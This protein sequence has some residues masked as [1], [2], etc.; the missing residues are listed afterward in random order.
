MRLP[1]LQHPLEKQVTSLQELHPT[2]DFLQTHLQEPDFF[3]F[4]SNAFL[5]RPILLKYWLLHPFST[6]KPHVKTAPRKD[7]FTFFTHLRT[8]KCARKGRWVISP[9]Y[10]ASHPWHFCASWDDSCSKIWPPLGLTLRCMPYG[11]GT[12]RIPLQRILK[13]GRPALLLWAKRVEP[14]NQ[15]Y[16]WVW[17]SLGDSLPELNC[18]A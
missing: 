13:Q 3:W 5:K 4:T 15:P 17:K 2:R 10:R 6:R 14:N 18:V 16:S 11:R 1:T 8:L 7:F 9:D 12:L